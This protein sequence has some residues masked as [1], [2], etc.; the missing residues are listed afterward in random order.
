MKRKG[1]RTQRT[2]ARG[3][4]KRP[5]REC[6]EPRPIGRELGGMTSGFENSRFSCEVVAVATLNC[7]QGG[8][9]IMRRVVGFDSK[10]G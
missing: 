4:A 6:A 10:L 1:A 7:L 9:Y 3:T 8:F 2:P 5:S